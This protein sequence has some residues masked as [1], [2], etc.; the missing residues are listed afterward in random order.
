MVERLCRVRWCPRL[1][2]LLGLF[3]PVHNITS[4]AMRFRFNIILP[5][6]LRSSKEVYLLMSSDIFSTTFSYFSFVFSKGSEI[7]Q[8]SK[9]YF[10]MQGAKWR[11]EASSTLGSTILGCF[12]LGACEMIHVSVKY[13]RKNCSNDEQ[14][15]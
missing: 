10:Q 14:K 3:N 7:C 15:K 12:L 13:I 1:N 2:P 8:K 9:S 11:H 4:Y 5:D 6:M